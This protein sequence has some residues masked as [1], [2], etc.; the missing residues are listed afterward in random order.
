MVFYCTG[1]KPENSN[2]CVHEKRICGISSIM[3][4][5]QFQIPLTMV[6]E[7]ASFINNNGPCLSLQLY[8]QTQKFS[9]PLSSLPFIKVSSLPL[10]PFAQNMYEALC[11]MPVYY[12]HC[13]VTHLETWPTMTCCLRTR[14]K[15]PGNFRLKPSSR[16]QK[17]YKS[18]W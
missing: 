5:M 10:L 15:Y 3:N 14:K 17:G 8:L 4:P 9:F 7:K 6:L 18:E 16:R 2:T 13:I 11:T 12:G 1:P